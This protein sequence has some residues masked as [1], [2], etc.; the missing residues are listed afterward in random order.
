MI[1]NNI[2]TFILL[3]IH[4]NFI[5]LLEISMF[6]LSE[7]PIT[8]QFFCSQLILFFG[9][10]IA[11]TS[12]PHCPGNNH[13][14]LPNISQVNFCQIKFP[15]NWILLEFYI[16]F[17]ENSLQNCCKKD[18]G[19]AKVS[20]GIAFVFITCHSVRWI[21]NIYELWQVEI[22]SIKYHYQ[23]EPSYAYMI[24]DELLCK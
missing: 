23:P 15:M 14:L 7:S 24:P 11:K 9:Q 17:Q 16:Y 5:L 20:L 10:E 4:I 13:L 18:A 12:V 6:Q 22:F 3:I 19:M 21:P 1:P 2:K 8:N